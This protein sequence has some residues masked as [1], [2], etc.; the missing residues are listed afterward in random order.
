VSGVQGG[1]EEEGQTGRRVH[2]THNI[3]SCLLYFDIYMYVCVCMCV[4]VCVY[5][6][7]SLCLLTD[8]SGDG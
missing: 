5:Y 8:G 6:N 3:V 1:E 7:M 2:D 4:C